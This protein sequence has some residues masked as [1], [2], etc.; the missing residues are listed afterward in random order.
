MIINTQNSPTY[1]IAEKISEELRPFIRSGKSYIRDMEQF[2]DKS[3]ECQT[4][5][6][7]KN[8]QF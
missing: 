1:K 3:Q 6:R 8:G 7:P 2:V 5:R 4:R